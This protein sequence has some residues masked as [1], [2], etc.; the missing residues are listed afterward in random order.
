MTVLGTPGKQNEDAG[1]EAGR[2]SNTQRE[3]LPVEF[4]E[5]TANIR[6]A[7]REIKNFILF[8][9]QKQNA[10]AVMAVFT[11]LLALFAFT[12][13]LVTAFQIAP[14][15]KSADAAKKSA[16]TLAAQLEATERPWLKVD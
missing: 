4:R 12:Q 3:P 13:T 11:F 5:F 2:P 6:E 14:L 7:F 1:K 8:V 16:D 9:R 15:R 10:S